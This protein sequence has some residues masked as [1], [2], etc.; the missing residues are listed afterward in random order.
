MT[1][2]LSRTS[3]YL[4]PTGCNLRTHARCAKVEVKNSRGPDDVLIRYSTE[5]CALNK[6][7]C[8]TGGDQTKSHH[9]E[10]THNRLLCIC[11]DCWIDRFREGY[12]KQPFVP[13][14]SKSVS[15]ANC[16]FAYHLILRLQRMSVVRAAFI[17]W[18][19]L[20]NVRFVPFAAR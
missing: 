6:Y 2:T 3:K 14:Q 10:S 1:P 5:S 7:V 9:G 8:Q 17:A 16:K 19:G 12:P 15:S 18:P 11:E 4:R 13:S 20:F